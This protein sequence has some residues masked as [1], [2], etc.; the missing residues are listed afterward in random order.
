MELD[1]IMD[2]NQH[3]VARPV[4]VKMWEAFSRHVHLYLRTGGT[5]LPKYHLMMHMLHRVAIHGNPSSYSTYRDESLNGVL[6]KIARSCHRSA[7]GFGCHWKYQLL[8]GMVGGARAAN[9][10]P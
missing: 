10:H 1:G 7:F 6:A 9:L 4:Q 8:C 3:S 2:E 5:C